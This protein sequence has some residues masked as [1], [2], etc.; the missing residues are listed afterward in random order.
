MDGILNFFGSEAGQRRRAALNDLGRNIGYYIPP[1]LRGLLGAA[2]EMTPTS[3]LERAARASQSMVSP[4]RTA[5]ERIGDLGTML[6]ETAGV[7]APAM[8]ANRAAMPAAEALQEGLLGFSVGAQDVGRAVVDR[9]NQPGQM[10][11]VYSNPLLGPSDD[12]VPSIRAYHGSPHDFD[13][14]RM[15]AIGTGEGA[16]AYG[17]GLYFAEA[18]GVAR[19]YRDALSGR[20]YRMAGASDDVANQF[21][22]DVVDIFEA[23]GGDRGEITSTLAR[24]RNQV[25]RGLQDAGVNNISKLDDTFNP[26]FVADIKA[27]NDRAERLAAFLRSD[28]AQLDQGRM[29]EV[30]INAN[31]EDFIDYDAPLSAQ[32]E[33]VQRF[34]NERW[35]Q[36]MGRSPDPTIEGEYILKM[37]SPQSGIDGPDW[38]LRGG[39]S[40][41]QRERLLEAGIPGVRYLDAGSRGAGDGSRNYVVFDENL[42]N[43]V[44]R[45]GIAGAAALLGLSVADVESAMAGTAPDGLLAQEPRQ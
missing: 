4:N 22:Q 32:S 34:A 40:D 39:P 10:P 25:T 30:N 43:I 2:A 27:T 26:L 13:R 11:T 31:S 38:L 20:N 23:S 7:V 45:Y 8:V 18:E 29:Y 17:P 9:L 14:F 36:I 28:Y 35:Q 44:R 37:A 21:G 3:T 1:E 6:S 19:Q 15:S 5:S 42:I 41:A 16:Q 12:R 33:N 24:L